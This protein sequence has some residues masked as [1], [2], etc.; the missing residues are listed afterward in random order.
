MTTMFKA[1]ALSALVYSSLVAAA[2]PEGFSAPEDQARRLLAG[3]RSA[4]DR[5]PLPAPR[6]GKA[7]AASA[8]EHAQ[9]LLQ[10]IFVEGPAAFEGASSAV[11][12]ELDGHA[13]ARHL[14]QR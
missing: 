8:Q 1:L 10:P 2:E 11:Y 4:V 12:A 6:V 13:Q 3:P 7:T 9:N 5:M 14:W